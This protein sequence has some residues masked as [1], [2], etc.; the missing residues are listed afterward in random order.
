M[1]DAL[2]VS[3]MGLTQRFTSTVNDF[4]GLIHV[5]ATAEV[6]GHQLNMAVFFW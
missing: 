2:Q 4:L 3:E 1:M 5:L 6:Q